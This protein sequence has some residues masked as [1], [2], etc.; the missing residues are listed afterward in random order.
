MGDGGR[1]FAGHTKNYGKKGGRHPLRSHDYDDEEQWNNTNW[2]NE[3]SFRVELTGIQNIDIIETIMVQISQDERGKMKALHP[4]PYLFVIDPGVIITADQRK[5]N[6]V[7]E[8]PYNFL[9]ISPGNP[10]GVKENLEKT[11]VFSVC[12]LPE[13]CRFVPLFRQNIFRTVGLSRIR[14]RQVELIINYNVSY[15][16]KKMLAAKYVEMKRRDLV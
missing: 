4:K 12:F 1:G 9:F 3:N 11:Q 13:P 5:N 14:D 16:D 15:K 10:V 2:Y 6:I 7:V 8:N